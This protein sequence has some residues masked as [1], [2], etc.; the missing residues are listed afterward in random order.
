M[1][2][3]EQQQLVVPGQLQPPNELPSGVE[4]PPVPLAV[5]P[6]TGR[7]YAQAATSSPL[8]GG[9]LGL[10]GK[11]WSGQAHGRQVQQSLQG[12]GA[13]Q[14]G[15]EGPGGQQ[16]GDHHQ[17]LPEATPRQCGPQGRCAAQT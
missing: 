4:G 7:S 6:P 1:S 11:R 10:R 13:W 9:Q 17:G 5:I 12:V 3:A 15:V 16:S 14:Q 8:D 2:A